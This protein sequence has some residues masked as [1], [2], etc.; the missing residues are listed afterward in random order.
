MYSTYGAI[1]T[2]YFSV[3]KNDPLVAAKLNGNNAAAG[4]AVMMVK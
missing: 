2:D 4:G 3:T 1:E